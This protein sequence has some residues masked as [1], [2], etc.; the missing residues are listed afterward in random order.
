MKVGDLVK[1]PSGEH[2]IVVRCL[3]GDAESLD[4]RFWLVEFVNGTRDTM[5]ESFMELVNESR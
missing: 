4:F 5:R 1:S 3:C 2:A